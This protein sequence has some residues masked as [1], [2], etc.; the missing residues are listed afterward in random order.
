MLFLLAGITLLFL[1]LNMAFSD[2]D[3]MHPS[4]VL[5]AVFLVY[6]MVCLSVRST[7]EIQIHPQTVMSV[8]FMLTIFT[9]VGGIMRPVRKTSAACRVSEAAPEVIKVPVWLVAVL[10]FLQLAS[11]WFFIKYLRA[12]RDAWQI[13]GMEAESITG[14]ASE[15]SLSSLINLYDTMTKFWPETFRK[16][17]VPIPLAYRI[18]NPVCSAAAYMLIYVEANNFVAAHRLN[19]LHI[20]SIVL[21]CVLIVLNGSR[22]PLLRVIVMASVLLYILNCRKYPA[23]KGSM[24]TLIKIAVLFAGAA[25]MMI[26]VLQIMG[27]SEK[28]GALSRYFFI[29]VGAPLVNF[30]SFIAGNDIGLFRGCAGVFETPRLFGAQTFR[31][32]YNYIGKLFDIDGLRYTGISHF[33]FSSNGIEIGNVYTALYYPVY[34]FGYAGIIMMIPITA[35]YYT[36]TYKK[37]MERPGSKVID[38]RLYIYAYLYNDLVMQAFS[39]SFFSTVLD[40]PFLKLLLVSYIY[41][42]V[43]FESRFMT[44][45]ESRGLKRTGRWAI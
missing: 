31:A 2:K 27:R 11:I 20:V 40:A 12:I 32:G 3:Y 24:K 17:S 34:D 30:D 43:I 15:P 25:V 10:I 21:M 42:R 29:Y 6:E 38:F 45:K 26:V 13:N 35:L 1:M 37:C 36:V 23:S 16:L 33:A 19:F 5:C 22:T 44:R 4:V 9:V 8:T 39:S 41:D 28:V 14:S 7:Y 18:L